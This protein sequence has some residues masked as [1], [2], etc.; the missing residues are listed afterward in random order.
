M[1]WKRKALIMKTC[2]R[3]RWSEY[4]RIFLDAKFDIIR[5]ERETDEASLALLNSGFKAD[6]DFARF[7]PEELAVKSSRFILKKAQP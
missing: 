3:L 1:N 4:E 2:N 7:L 5:H 6:Q